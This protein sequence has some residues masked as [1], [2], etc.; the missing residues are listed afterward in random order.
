MHRG[1]HPRSSVDRL[2]IPRVQGG[3]GLLSVKDCVELERSNLFDY[4]ANNSE[5]LLKTATEELQLRTKINGKN[6]EE[7]ENE[8]Q[9]ARKEKAMHGQF[10]RETEGMQDQRRWQWLKAG[11]LKWGTESLICAAQELAL[12]TNAIK[13]GI[14]TKTCHRYAGSANRKLKVSPYCQF[15]QS[16]LAGNQHRKRHDKL[17]KKVLWLLCKKF[18]IECEDKL[19]SHQPEPRK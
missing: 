13:N 16:V 10:L 11:E 19:F 15:C 4:A 14:D 18:E 8:I 1:L 6:K 17:G 5:R 9:A 7:R 12:R 3:R 2:Y